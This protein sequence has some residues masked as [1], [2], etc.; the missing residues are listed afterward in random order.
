MTTGLTVRLD[1]SAGDVSVLALGVDEATGALV[2]A[3]SDD[4]GGERRVM[5][6]EIRHVRLDQPLTAAV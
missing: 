1:M 3:D 5:V 4:P 6:G 2:V